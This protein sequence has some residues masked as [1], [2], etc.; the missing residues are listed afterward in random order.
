MGGGW[1]F[2]ISAMD[3]CACLMFTCV[4]MSCWH[5]TNTVWSQLPALIRSEPEGKSLATYLNLVIQGGNVFVLA[6]IA[7]FKGRV[8][9]GNTLLLLVVISTACIFGISFFWDKT[10]GSHS[11]ALIVLA[12]AAGSVG[13]VSNVVSWPFVSQ[14][15]PV[16]SSALSFGLSFSAVLVS[17]LAFG[18]DVGS[19]DPN[20]DVRADF[21]MAAGTTTVCLLAAVIV[22]RTTLF[23]GYKKTDTNAAPTSFAAINRDALDGEKAPLLAAPLTDVERV[24]VGDESMELLPQQRRWLVTRC[25]IFVLMTIWMFG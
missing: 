19:D 2:G 21:L 11:I 12:F 25:C 22:T 24:R 16:L 20:F 3:L 7:V 9:V 8:S 17:M 18:Q 6:Y 14:Y 4:G 1:L 23:D 5:P 13:N 15:R 10:V